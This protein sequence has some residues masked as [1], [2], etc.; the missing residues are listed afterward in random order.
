VS[1][2]TQYIYDGNKWQNEV[3]TE[4]KSESTAA[5]SPR[6]SLVLGSYK[7]G[8]GTAGLLAGVP[9]E[10]V[11]TTMTYGKYIQFKNCWFR[12]SP[13][14]N[15]DLVTSTN[16]NISNILFEDCLFRAQKPQWATAAVRGGHHTTFSRC[17]FRGCVDGISQANSQGYTGDQAIKVYGC[18]FHNMA[19]F[20][21]DPGAAGGVYDNASHVDLIQ[22]RGGMN[23]HFKGNNFDAML[24]PAIGQAST[25]SQ[26]KPELDANGQPTG[27]TLHISGNK[28]YP[29]LAATSVLMCSP[30]LGEL[31][32]VV[33]E[34]NWINGGSYSINMGGFVSGTVTIKNNKWGRDMR[35]GRTATI[36]AQRG[37]PL[38]ISGNTFSDDGT[39]ANMCKWG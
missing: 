15:K 33:M 18:W 2:V 23:F 19:Y 12:G 39:A 35:L 13:T 34:N 9:L 3:R 26:D 24:D 36:I 30:M 28:Y 27:K 4:R 32:N 8:A 1:P 5:V 20:S 10:Q 29:H 21:P 14:E 31:K 11:N 16:A 7:P 37:M 25:P 6:S 22:I 38:T 17:E